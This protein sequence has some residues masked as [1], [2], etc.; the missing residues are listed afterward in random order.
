MLYEFNP[1]SLVRSCLQGV[2]VVV[3]CVTITGVAADSFAQDSQASSNWPVFRGAQHGH[4]IGA[5]IPLE[6]DEDKNI[7]W[8][9]PIHGRGWSSPVIWGDQIWLTTATKDGKKMS[10][11]CVDLRSGEVLRDS[12]IHENEEPAFCHPVN[13][14]ASP[15]P[16]IEE[17]RVY[18][19]FGSYGT[20]CLNTKTGETIWQRLDFKCDHFRGPGSSPIIYENM[21]IVAFDGFDEQYVVALNKE[22]GETIWKT[23]REIDYGTDNGDLMKAYCTGSVFEVGGRPILVYPSAV[24]TVAYEA[25]TGEPIWTAYHAGM[26]ASARP[27][28]TKNGL[29]VLTNGMGKMVAVDPRGKGDITK[30]NIKWR[31]AEAIAKKSSQLIVGDRVFMVS[32]KGVAT[33]MNQENGE[34][35]W[36]ERIGGKYAAS[37]VFDGEKIMAISEDGLIKFFKADD[38]FK[39]LG[40]SK[41]GDGFMASPAIAGKRI[42]LRSLTHLYCVSSE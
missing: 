7:K 34:A 28:M 13:S 23:D 14:Y 17:G 22:S 27:V 30:S 6:I 16:A 42:V 5:K 10:A 24:A 29:V 32:D 40:K 3:C 41:L 33:C 38:E 37:P 9:T 1:T 36:R 19:H 11:I 4:A 15:T 2:L 20:T 39:L 31:A 8:K 26:N 35:I 25:K 21:L 12:V 18:I